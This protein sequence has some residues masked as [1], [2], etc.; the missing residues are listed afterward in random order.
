VINETETR[1]GRRNVIR[2]G[3]GIGVD[4]IELMIKSESNYYSSLIVRIKDTGETIKVMNAMHHDQL[5]LNNGCSI[6]AM[7]FAD[8]TVWDWSDI[9]S[10]PMLMAD[11]SFHSG[12]YNLGVAAQEGGF[13]VGTDEADYIHGRGNDDVLH[14]GGGDDTLNAA[15]GNDVLCGGSGNDTLHGGAG[16]DVY[17]FN[18]GDGQDV[19]NESS[20]SDSLVFNGIDYA[21][22]WFG[23]SGNHLIIDVLGEEDRVTV[24]NWYAGANYRVESIQA[25]ETAFLNNQMDQIIQALAAFG[26]PQGADGKWTGEQREELAPVLAACWQQNSGA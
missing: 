8:G 16:N 7:E 5:S 18:A 6:Q 17:V 9:I 21:D 20:G 3:E 1:A 12:I 24:N 25:G 2:L 11:D 22:L 19:I 14:G 10:R 23:R 26:V 4:D 13:V 15:N